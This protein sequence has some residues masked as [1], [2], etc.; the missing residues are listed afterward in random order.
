MKTYY[1]DGYISYT[2]MSDNSKWEEP[3]QFIIKAENKK[4]GKKQVEIMTKEKFETE[5]KTNDDKLD[6]IVYENFYQ[7]TDDARCS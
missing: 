1:V 5:L 7:T 3:F 6:K 4:H 2:D